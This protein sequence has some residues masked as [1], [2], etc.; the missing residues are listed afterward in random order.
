MSNLIDQ[1]RKNYGNDAV[2][3]MVEVLTSQII[4]S[5]QRIASNSPY[6]DGEVEFLIKKN[7]PQNAEI[8]PIQFTSDAAQQQ[9][10]EKALAGFAT[11]DSPHQQLFLPINL[12]NNCYSLAHITKDNNNQPQVSYFD[13]VGVNTPH[14]KLEPFTQEQALK[15]SS[16]PTHLVAALEQG[17]KISP[18]Q[19]NITTNR[20]QASF[21]NEDDQNK[22]YTYSNDGGAIVIDSAIALAKGNLKISGNK[23]EIAG[24]HAK[25]AE[26]EFQPVRN[27]D[28]QQSEELARNCRKNHLSELQDCLKKDFPHHAD[29]NDLSQ[30]KAEKNKDTKSTSTGVKLPYGALFITSLLA[31]IGSAAAVQNLRGNNAMDLIEHVTAE[32]NAIITPK[33]LPTPVTKSPSG[34][35]TLAP[36]PTPT[37]IPTLEPS[38]QPTIKP[39]GQPASQPTSQPSSYLNNPINPD[40]PLNQ[41]NCGNDG[42]SRQLISFIIGSGIGAIILGVSAAQREQCGKY[43]CRDVNQESSLSLLGYAAATATFTTAIGAAAAE[44]DKATDN[45]LYCDTSNSIPS[46]VVDVTDNQTGEY[47]INGAIAGLSFCAVIGLLKMIQLCTDKSKSPSS[48]PSYR[49][50]GNTF[51]LGTEM[52]SNGGGGRI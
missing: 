21:F 45:E 7:L 1:F 9:N 26:G 32:H 13:P 42:F 31:S 34:A 47:A 28:V 30:K 41:D 10:L 51:G 17:L 2:N 43:F 18:D 6:Q 52:V 44:I 38:A 5:S 4:A 50:S 49:A 27:F 15:Y 46:W 36:T 23:G 25:T 22:R 14:N 11:K 40:N 48:S 16:I 33:N 12:G 35:P 39:T 8:L 20:I 19:I 24:L 37:T 29:E 3:K